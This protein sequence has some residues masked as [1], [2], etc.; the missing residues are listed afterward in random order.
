MQV[1]ARFRIV[2]WVM[3]WMA[4][5]SVLLAWDVPKNGPGGDAVRLQGAY[6]F[7]RDH[8]I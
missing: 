3:I 7:E 2:G 5:C 4:G 1:F 8:W 6:R